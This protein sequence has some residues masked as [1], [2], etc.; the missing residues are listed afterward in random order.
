M[1]QPRKRP[2]KVGVFLPFMEYMIDGKTPRW[3]DFTAMAQCAEDAGFDSI[4]LGDHLIIHSDQPISYAGGARDIGSWECWSILSA[5]AAVTRRIELGPLVACTSFRN[6]ALL[7]KMADTVDE[8]SGG[9]LILGLG[10]G[11]HEPEFRA[12]GYPHDHRASRFEEALTIIHTLLRKGQVDFAG[13]YYQV[14]DCELRPRGPRP[15]GP[16]ILIGSLGHGPRMLRLTAQYADYWNGWIAF[17]KSHPSAIPPLRAAVDAACRAVGRDPL[18]LTRTAA[19]VVNVSGQD[20]C[21]FPS[22]LKGTPDQ[23]AAALR[24]FAQEGIAHVQ[25]LLHPY[26]LASIEALRPVLH[27]LDQG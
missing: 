3:T 7:T 15:A 25:L 23:L 9:R 18:S 2:L 22:P 21:P 24:S 1:D 11:D 5:L 16:P 10:A 26:T 4:W 8:I 19:I 6:P 12:F 27:V 13:T 17:D 20:D 14:R